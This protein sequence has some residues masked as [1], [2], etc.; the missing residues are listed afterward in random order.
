MKRLLAIAALATAAVAVTPGLASARVC[1]GAVD[2]EC[3][4]P[5][6]DELDCGLVRCQLWIAV[7]CVR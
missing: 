7:A 2:T 3:S 5:C 1:E 6:H 4:P